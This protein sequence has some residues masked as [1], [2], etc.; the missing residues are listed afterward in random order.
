MNRFRIGC[1]TRIDKGTTQSFGGG[2]HPVE[3]D[4][5]EDSRRVG[6]GQEVGKEDPRPQEASKIYKKSLGQ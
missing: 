2:G 1:S 6:E 3:E 4:K 5:Q